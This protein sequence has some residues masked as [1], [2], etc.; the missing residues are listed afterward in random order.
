MYLFCIFHP[1]IRCCGM[2]SERENRCHPKNCA[3]RENRLRPKK[4]KRGVWIMDVSPFKSI[5]RS[6]QKNSTLMQRM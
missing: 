5:A 3:M 6:D 1:I 2:Y 4:R